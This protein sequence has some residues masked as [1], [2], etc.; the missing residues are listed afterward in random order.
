[1]IELMKFK[2]A[3]GVGE[4]EFRSADQQ[5][6]QSF[7]YRQPG[8]LRRTTARDDGGNWIVIDVWRSAADSDACAIRWNDDQVAQRFMSLIDGTTIRGERYSLLD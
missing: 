3:P 7:A 4:A 2:L 5:V 1:V 8:L 6:Q